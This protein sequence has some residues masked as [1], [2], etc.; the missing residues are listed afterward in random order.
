MCN[1]YAAI[2]FFTFGIFPMNISAS[3]GGSGKSGRG[4]YLRCPGCISCG[5]PVLSNRAFI[6]SATDGVPLADMKIES[7]CS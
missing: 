1:E 7:C 6:L 3:L 5:N 4:P 2:N